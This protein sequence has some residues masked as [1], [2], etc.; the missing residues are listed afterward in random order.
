[1]FL[2]VYFK[3]I[4]WCNDLNI[5]SIDDVIIYLDVENLWFKDSDRIFVSF[6]VC[7]NENNF[8]KFKYLIKIVVYVKICFIFYYN[9]WLILVI[10]F[11]VFGL[12][13][14]FWDVI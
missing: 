1:M 13:L 3:L 11:L 9:I 8:F 12:I 4:I 7:E 5:F 2:C 10:W 6:F 14:K